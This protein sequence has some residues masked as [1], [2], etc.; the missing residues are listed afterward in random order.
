MQMLN[1]KNETQKKKN[2]FFSLNAFSGVL[3]RT[4]LQGYKPKQLMENNKD[5]ACKQ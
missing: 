2:L 4:V 1:V 3:P 5:S